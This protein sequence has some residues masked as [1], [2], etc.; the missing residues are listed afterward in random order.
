MLLISHILHDGMFSRECFAEFSVSR[1]P[2]LRVV[3]LGE[4]TQVNRT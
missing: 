4:M 1:R 3:K 2:K